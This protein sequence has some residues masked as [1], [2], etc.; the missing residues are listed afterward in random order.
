MNKKW[1]ISLAIIVLYAASWY[2]IGNNQKE[3]VYEYERHLAEARKKADLKI[4]VD[5]YA[6]YIAALDLYDTI[7]IRCELAEYYKKNNMLDDLVR[8]SD[9][10]IEAYRDKAE[11]YEY[12][13][14]CFAANNNYRDLFDILDTADLR[15]VSSEYLTSLSKEYMYKYKIYI[16]SDYE[17]IGTYSSGLFRVQNKNGLWGYMDAYGDIAIRCVYTY[18]GDFSYIG[19]ACVSKD[20]EYYLI[21][22]SGQKKFADVLRRE[23]NACGLLSNDIMPVKFGDKYSFTDKDFNIL[24]GEYEY[25][26]S[27]NNGVAPVKTGGYWH[28][29]NEKGKYVSDQTYTNIFIDDKGIGF[30]NQRGYAKNENGYFLINTQGQKVGNKVFED[31]TLFKENSPTAVKE[32]GKW[33]YINAEGEYVI[34]NQYEEARPFS[35]GLAAVKTNGLWGYI[36]QDNE[37]VIDAQFDEALDFTDQGTAAIKENGQ[38]K[39]IE[40]YSRSNNSY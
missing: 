39:L 3:I 4:S 35:N 11:G 27:F 26:G 33:G 1:L 31:V 8:W 34:N 14:Y 21:N 40:I 30:R 24:F 9:Q 38:W 2:S 23:I 19:Y 12:L 25:A 20:N 10:I 22:K 7:E 36:T 15:G 29:I 17:N 28:I 13:A 5:A 37:L 32:N 16:M 6:N 18:A